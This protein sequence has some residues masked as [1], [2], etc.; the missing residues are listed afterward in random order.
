MQTVTSAQFI[1]MVEAG[2]LSWPPFQLGAW[3]YARLATHPTDSIG[4]LYRT[5]V[6]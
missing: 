5:A 6:P 3:V 1:S 2:N 4:E